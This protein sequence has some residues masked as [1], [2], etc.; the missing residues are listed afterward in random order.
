MD[1]N[2]ET[3]GPDLSATLAQGSVKRLLLALPS[4]VA[5]AGAS[6]W[7]SLKNGIKSS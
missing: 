1:N 5:V 7:H 4:L 6:V 3:D 2:R